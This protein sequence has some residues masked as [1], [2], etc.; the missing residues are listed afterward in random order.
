[1]G[2]DISGSESSCV[3]WKRHS[4][5]SRSREDSSHCHSN[6]AGTKSGIS[7]PADL[8]T[9]HL[10]GGSIQRALERCHC[11]VREGRSGVALQAEVQEITRPHPEVFQFY[12]FSISSIFSA[13]ACGM[14]TYS[15]VSAAIFEFGTWSSTTACLEEPKVENPNLEN[16][17]VEN[18]TS[19]AVDILG[20]R[21]PRQPVDPDASMERDTW[22]NQNKETVA[23]LVPTID[24][25]KRDI[26]EDTP[27]YQKPLIL[28][29]L[30]GV[31][32]STNAQNAQ[33]E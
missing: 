23:Q 6:F 2:V 1:M 19:N 3:R 15:E 29:T 10:D 16:L 8:G 26:Q 31:K 17:E 4:S 28:L 20:N 11:Y 25:D 12:R 14:V 21:Y 27:E 18:D 33:V 7:K 24:T 5:T 32:T 9:K 30:N 13:H 22:M